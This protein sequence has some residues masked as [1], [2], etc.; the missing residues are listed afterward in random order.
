[1]RLRL[2]AGLRGLDG[3]A[4]EL[5]SSRR[6]LEA[7]VRALEARRNEEVASELAD[8]A[9]LRRRCEASEE[10]ARVAA[11]RA[12]ALESRLNAT[13][14]RCAYLESNASP[15]S[16]HANGGMSTTVRYSEGKTGGVSFLEASGVEPM[17]A[18]LAEVR[19]FCSGIAALPSQVEALQ[20]QWDLLQHQIHQHQGVDEA[21]D[22]DGEVKARK[23]QLWRVLTI[24]GVL[25]LAVACVVATVGF[26]MVMTDDKGMFHFVRLGLASYYEMIF[27]QPASAVIEFLSENIYE[28]VAR[29]LWPAVDFAVAKADQWVAAPVYTYVLSPLSKLAVD[30]HAPVAAFVERMY[31]S[32]N[33]ILSGV[34]GHIALGFQ[35]VIE[36]IAASWQVAIAFLMQGVSDLVTYGKEKVFGN[37]TTA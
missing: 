33:D 2:E 29:V 19:A 35:T 15:L 1:M 14:G 31:G 20:R 23:P 16:P 18:E 36:Y 4:S 32:L 9:S 24:I 22:G 26:R 17:A 21:G 11:A 6:A 8:I 13:E 30:L 3:R 12:H 34:W 25:L 10:A 27:A 7:S 28:P 37:A 5:E